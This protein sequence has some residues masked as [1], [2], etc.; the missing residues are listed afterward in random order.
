MANTYIVDVGD[1]ARHDLHHIRSRTVPGIGR[2]DTNF[3]GHIGPCKKNPPETCVLVASSKQLRS[4][5]FTQRHMHIEG[6][7]RTKTKKFRS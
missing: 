3:D 2:N 5:T 4:P 6:G 7:R 1:S